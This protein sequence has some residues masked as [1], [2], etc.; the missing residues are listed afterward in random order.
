MNRLTQRIQRLERYLRVETAS[1]S[2]PIAG[3]ADCTLAGQQGVRPRGQREP[4]GDYV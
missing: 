3:A 1:C 2:V 4:G